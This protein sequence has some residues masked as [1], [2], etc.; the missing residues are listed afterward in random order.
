ME[1]KRL[2]KKLAV[3][4]SLSLVT[5]L[6]MSFIIFLCVVKFN[7]NIYKGVYLGNEDISGYTPEK[8]AKYVTNI[9]NELKEFELDLYQ[10]SNKIYG[11]TA[12]M[13]DFKVDV[14][15]TISSVINFGKT[16]NL[17]NDLKDIFEARK[18][19]KHFKVEY[20][21]NLDKMQTLLKNIDLTI[22][23]RV[24]YDT[25]SVEDGKLILTKG[26]DG[27]IIDSEE[28]AKNIIERFES[29][30]GSMLTLKLKDAKSSVLSA[31]SIKKEIVKQP[32]NAYIDES[33]AP[34]KFV[35]EV[36]GLDVD[37]LE[38]QNG[39]DEL[40]TMNFGENVEKTLQILKPAVYLSD[41]YY[42]VY[43]DKIASFTTYF[44]GSQT[45]RA[46]NIEI[47]AGY[48]ND[49]IVMP[50]EIFSFNSAVGEITKAKGYLM[51]ATFSGGRVVDGLGGGVCQVSST[52][53]NTALLAN[54]E[55]VERY[56]HS[57]PVSYVLPSRD[58]TIYVGVLDFKFRN[59]RTHAIKI[60]TSYSPTGTLTISMYGTKEDIEYDIDIESHVIEEL[61]PKTEY[62]E[63]ESVEKGKE[64]VVQGGSSG[65]VSESYLVK[66]LNGK[67]IDKQLI[68]KDVYSA[69][70]RIVKVSDK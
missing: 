55:I 37:I 5:L 21:Y 36:E 12:D 32:K 39:I 10:D 27:Y 6:V 46:K 7:K 52:L 15:K 61:K 38:I 45:N 50:G 4:I 33:V 62:I 42:D 41:I 53:Y 68:S 18:A 64:E 56:A 59:T 67:V 11:V 57:L 60:V 47:A 35:K 58:A 20:E 9:S 28:V 43:N 66:K 2:N 14:N 65:A 17:Y 29:L 1:K 40:L 70:N 54:L 23:G 19:E 16:G 44:A 31:E 51:A 48:I 30:D 25:Y 13:I 69:V 22:E 34:V 49:I 26:K 8:L 63:D 3:I 24:I